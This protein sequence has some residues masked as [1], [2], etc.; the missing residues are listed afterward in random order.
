MAVRRMS[1][2]RG[3]WRF[4]RHDAGRAAGPSPWAYLLLYAACQGL[5][6]WSVHHLHFA[7][8]WPANAVLLAAVLQL[9]RRPALW[10]L[11]AGFCLNL[12]TN[13]LRG[14]MTIYTV[15]NPLLNMAQVLV[16]AVLARRLCGAALD[17]RRPIRLFRFA[18]GAAVPAVA[19][20]T[21]LAGLIV[22]ALG[23]I[24]PGSLSFR[25]H[26]L[27]DMELLA[28]MIFTPSLLLLA[29]SHR[30]SRDAVAPPM[31]VMALV[32]LT[33]VITLWV[34]GQ[35]LAPILFMVFPPLILLAFRLSPPLTALAVIVITV[36]GGAATL[37]GHGP[38][39]LTH[40]TPEPAL[41][42]IPTVMRQMNVF[43]LFLLAVVGTALPI[44]TL[45]SERRR[46][47]ARLRART[48][49]AVAALQ[50]AEAADAAKSRFLA[51]MSHEMRTPLTGV[52]GYADLLSRR[53]GLDAEGLRQVEAVRLCS[54]TMLRLVEDLLEVSRGGQEV[55]LKPACVRSLVEEAIAPAREWAAVRGL[56][57]SLTIAPE[58]EGGVMTDARR[59]RQVLHHLAG[60]AVKFTSRGAVAVVVERQGDS[61]RLIVSDTGCG[62][63]E[64]I[65]AGVFSLFEQADA[66]TRRVHEGAGVGLALAK[67]H[68]DR[69]GGVVGVESE[70]WRGS[71]FTVVIPAR[72]VEVAP[73]GDSAGAGSAGNGRLHVLIVDDHPANRDLLRI[74]LQAADCETTEAADGRQAL[75]AVGAGRF[76]L[77]L[78]D[79]RMPV[80]D[81]LDAT[82]AIRA[83]EG[84]ARD[85]PILAVTAEAMPEDAARCIAAGMD[86]HLA[87]PVTQA[88]LYAA[89]DD[90]LQARALRATQ[91]A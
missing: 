19:L 17:M 58:A 44:T 25:L 3:R 72:R 54:E 5:G 34:F 2:G 42:A 16:A 31:E 67:N 70:Q 8:M 33:T 41:A 79:V 87:K 84:A 64:D 22:V 37:T 7:V 59:L 46:L 20:S 36:I 49:A 48:E 65:L 80:M 23:R 57:F 81:G 82:R 88:R 76:D 12:V 77:V 53:P 51:L 11:I 15:L 32:G 47:V 60:N 10:L 63:S 74:M 39:T 52:T 24:A 14:D 62:M 9:H 18:I 50:R 45:S 83:L 35:N 71:T 21:V 75:D 89:M 27:F 1:L 85:L 90:V 13:A 43:H 26:H 29:R 40:V 56:D 61:L 91:A 78:M 69:L 38:V 4:F 55:A 28:M 73:E 66:T 6:L 68:I 86:G 30:F